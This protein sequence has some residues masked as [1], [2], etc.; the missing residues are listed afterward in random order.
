MIFFQYNAY[1]GVSP[2]L[3]FYGTI[4]HGNKKMA[5]FSVQENVQAARKFLREVRAES[6]KVTWATKEQTIAATTVVIFCV[7]CVAV[8]LALWDTVFSY[9]FKWI[10]R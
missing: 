9:L 7:V 4:H 1:F 3:N 10:G 6:M 2:L 8:F 5:K